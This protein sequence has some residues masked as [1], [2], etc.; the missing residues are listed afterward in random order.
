MRE[1]RNYTNTLN[2]LEI[3]KIRLNILIDKK[4][5]I[6]RKYFK[7]TAQLSQ[8]N[9]QPNLYKKDKMALYI[10]ELEKENEAT[11][12]SLNEELTEVK[13]E[14]DTLQYYL[15]LMNYNLD[16]MKGIE[17]YLYKEIVKNGNKPKQAVVKASSKFFRHES[18]I[19]SEFYP[20]VK[21]ELDKLFK[22]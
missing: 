14:V 3:A 4:E 20:K 22:K 15:N 13:N 10:N 11:G 1:F 21:T 7:T 5:K 18:K 17:A 19:W 16:N 9:S 12:M 2:E 6:Y 8:T